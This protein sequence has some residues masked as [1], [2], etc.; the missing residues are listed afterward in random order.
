MM[1]L[2][3]RNRFLSGFGNRDYLDEYLMEQEE[4][5]T[6][7]INIAENDNRYKIEMGLPGFNKD[8][9]SIDLE[10]DCLIIK[11]EKEKEKSYVKEEYTRREFRMESFEKSFELP[12]GID[13]DR[14]SAKFE[15]GLLE[16][17]IPKT[18][19]NPKR[20]KTIKVS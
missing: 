17:E 10:K 5:F 14:I 2:P 8:D 12:P 7:A 15:D 18:E 9:F 19:N 11:G 4:E 13:P 6:P 20:I 16:V 1:T 3:K